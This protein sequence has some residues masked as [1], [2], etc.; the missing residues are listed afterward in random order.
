VLGLPAVDLIGH[1]LG[2]TIERKENLTRVAAA[3]VRGGRVAVWQDAGSPDWWRPF[4]AWPQH[5]VR[6]K[7]LEDWRTERVEALLVISDRCLPA[8]LP[9]KHTLVYR[10][11][12]LVAGVGCKRNTSQETIASWVQTVFAA[13]GLAEASLAAVA[14]VMLKADEPG[15]IRFAEA[16]HVPLLAYAA[17]EL[18]N[19]PGVATPSERVRAKIGIASVAEAAALKAAG[20]DRLLVVKQVGP[21]VTLAVAR[22]ADECVCTQSEAHQA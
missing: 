15:L 18:A 8:A 14:T 11:Q 6:L 19:Q 2:W 20:A 9:E 10:P 7:T 21:G 5:F 22:R 1:E 13:Q 12:T 4:G 3:V 17:S 16:R